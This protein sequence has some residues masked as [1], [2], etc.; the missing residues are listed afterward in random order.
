M[1]GGAVS[2]CHYNEVQGPSRKEEFGGGGHGVQTRG[3]KHSGVF[4]E[5]LLKKSTESWAAT[6]ESQQVRSLD[7]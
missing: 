6:E 7:S 2:R 4:K 1:L 5:L 3:W